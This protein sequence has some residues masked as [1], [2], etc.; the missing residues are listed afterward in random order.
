M[1]LDCAGFHRIYFLLRVF[2]WYEQEWLTVL[3]ILQP[4]YRQVKH[5]NLEFAQGVA[6]SHLKLVKS[7]VIFLQILPVFTCAGSNH[8]M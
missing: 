4:R 2:G 8:R 7:R 1:T 3:S 5:I 6:D